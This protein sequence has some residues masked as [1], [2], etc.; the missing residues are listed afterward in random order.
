MNARRKS[1]YSFIYLLK[2]LSAI[3][4][5]F[6]PYFH[7]FIFA[8]H[9]DLSNS[10]TDRNADVIGMNDSQDGD[11]SE[12]NEELDDVATSETSKWVFSSF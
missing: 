5:V 4:I 11:D 2:L 7:R 12:E 1:E 10:Q 9:R 3:F 6:S 8:F